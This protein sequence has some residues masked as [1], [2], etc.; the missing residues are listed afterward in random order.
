MRQ[1]DQRVFSF[2]KTGCNGLFPCTWAVS[3]QKLETFVYVTV[4]GKCLRGKCEYI[5]KGGLV[6]VCVAI[7][8]TICNLFLIMEKSAAFFSIYNFINV[9]CNALNKPELELSFYLIC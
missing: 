3:T 6:V 7:N 2:E 1:R 4:N 9:P 5:C 8:W